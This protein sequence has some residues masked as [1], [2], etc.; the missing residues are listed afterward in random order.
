[1]PRI[2]FDIGYPVVLI[3]KLYL[4][5]GKHREIVACDLDILKKLPDAYVEF[6]T[7]HKSGVTMHLLQLCDQLLSSGLSLSSIEQITRQRY[8][9]NYNEMKRRFLTYISIAK[10]PKLP[11]CPEKC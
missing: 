7:S 6:F 3:P 4:C 11:E 2:I 10:S 1:M 5:S 9:H 8:N